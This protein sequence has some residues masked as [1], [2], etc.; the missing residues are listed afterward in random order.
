MQLQVAPQRRAGDPRLLTDRSQ[1]K[2]FRTT[3]AAGICLGAG[4]SPVSCRRLGRLCL[5]FPPRLALRAKLAEDRH[6][7]RMVATLPALAL[8][9]DP[10][11]EQL[12]VPLQGRIGD[13][14]LRTDARKRQKR[15][16]SGSS[17][18]SPGRLPG[19]PGE[20]FLLQFLEYADGSGRISLSAPLALRR[21]SILVQLLVTL[22]RGHR[23][24]RASRNLAQCQQA[25]CSSSRF[26]HSGVPPSSN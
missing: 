17:P 12:H 10:I 15:C 14:R 20:P 1:R 3:T 19:T 24:F 26:A 11:T 13:A 7:F 5:G 2:Q 4:L 23:D 8:M 22:R 16:A 25:P 21:D 9:W 18:G 6:R